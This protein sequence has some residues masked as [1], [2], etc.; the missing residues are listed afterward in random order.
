M[1]NMRAM[2]GAKDH[3]QMA[4]MEQGNA[5]DF[6]F[7]ADAMAQHASDCARWGFG[8]EAAE[9]RETARTLRVQAILRRSGLTRRSG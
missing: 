8:P 3:P 7:L 6:E 4:V 9:A 2:R 5:S 1:A